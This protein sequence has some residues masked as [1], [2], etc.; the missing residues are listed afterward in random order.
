MLTFLSWAMIITF[1]VLVMAKKLSP[2]AAL[3]VVPIAF[4]LIGAFFGLYSEQATE[5]FKLTA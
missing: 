4:G 3:V 5:L 2:F 1:L